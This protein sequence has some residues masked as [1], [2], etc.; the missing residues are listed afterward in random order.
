MG[1]I[2]KIISLVSTKEVIK[3][4]GSTSA[5]CII[6]FNPLNFSTFKFYYPQAILQYMHILECETL[7]NDHIIHKNIS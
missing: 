3:A 2:M 7:F 5:G 6:I 1:L 4:A